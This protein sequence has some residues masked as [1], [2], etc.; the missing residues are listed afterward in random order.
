M[1]RSNITPYLRV[2]VLRGSSTNSINA[3]TSQRLRAGSKFTQVTWCLRNGRTAPENYPIDILNL[4]L[5]G[6][7]GGSSSVGTRADLKEALSGSDQSFLEHQV[8]S[9]CSKVELKDAMS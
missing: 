6:L 2:A 7:S 8:L 5:K 1:S 3:A 9:K 4:V